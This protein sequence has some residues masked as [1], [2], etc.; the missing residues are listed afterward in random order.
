MSHL[1]DSDLAKK[2]GEARLRLLGRQPFFAILLMHM[3]YGLDD[4]CETA[5]TDGKGIY[6]CPE[7]LEKL[8][9][10]E[11]EFVLLHE[12]LH[13]A[14]EHCF[15]Q[16]NRQDKRFN[17]A[18][19]IVV[20]DTI[21]EETDIQLPNLSL[22]GQT[23]WSRAPNGRSGTEYSVE[24]VYD[25]LPPMP[26]E[27]L[28]MFSDDHSKWPGAGDSD[29]NF[30]ESDRENGN[31]DNSGQWQNDKENET[32]FLKNCWLDRMIQAAV[33]V[34]RHERGRGIL[35]GM[36][37]RLLDKLRKPKINW[38][39]LLYNFI[40]QEISDYSFTQPDRR[41]QD[42]PV[43]LPGWYETSDKIDIWIAVDTSGSI[44]DKQLSVAF[45][46]I[47]GAVQSFGQSVWLSFFDAAITKP[48]RC[49]RETMPQIQPVGGGGTDFYPI[50][51]YLEENKNSFTPD[52][53]VI[54]T[55]GYAPFP[56]EKLA[57]GIPVLWLLNNNDSKPPWGRIVL[58]DC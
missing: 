30:L 3:R 57:R 27:P 8:D 54:M 44:D 12:I 18:C 45:S 32:T 11:T 40:R 16:G 17:I 23:I 56:P 42:N 5:Y 55:D 29:D 1:S 6:W 51:F 20:N 48:V 31:S 39:A 38:K 37:K 36:A 52:C 34:E 53:I 24:E 50:F 35:P 14:L 19:D 13:V 4:A 21:L 2:L 43:L 46:E 41:F 28:A 25:M 10:T 47:M 49:S 33:T 58:M 26:E 9:E 15:R 22:A 7:F